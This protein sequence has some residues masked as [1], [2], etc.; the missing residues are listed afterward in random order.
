MT[1]KLVGEADSGPEQWQYRAE[2]GFIGHISTECEWYKITEKTISR[3][4]TGSEDDY[5]L[6]MSLERLTASLSH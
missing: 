3:R 2:V 4:F 6:T 1:I 5:P